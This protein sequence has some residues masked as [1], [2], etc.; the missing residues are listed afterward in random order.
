M[1]KGSILAH[2]PFHT[3]TD[4]EY[5]E[6]AIQNVMEPGRRQ[7]NYYRTMTYK[8]LIDSQGNFLRGQLLGIFTG[9]VP[10]IIFKGQPGDYDKLQEMYETAVNEINFLYGAYQRENA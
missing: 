8:G 5:V 1:I 6:L 3:Y 2:K 10:R 4:L 7:A 9:S